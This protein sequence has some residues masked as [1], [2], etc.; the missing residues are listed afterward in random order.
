MQ[1]NVAGQ[2]IG[3]QLISSSDGSN[4]T[5]TVTVYVTGDAGTQ[6]IGSVGSGVCTHEGNG[7]HTYAPSQAETNYDLCAFTFIGTGA[8]SQTLQI[9][10]QHDANLKSI[11]GTVL[12][13]TAGQIAAGFKKVFDVAAPVF[14]AASINQTGDSYAR[15][16]APAGASV[17]ADVA[18][19]KS[20]SATLLARIGSFTGTGV[21]TILGM[22]KALLNK[23]ASTPSDVGGTFDASTDSTEAI[24]DNMGTA[25]TGDSYARL[26]APAGA[27]I[28]AD[29]AAI[30]AAMG[31]LVVHAGITLI[32]SLRMIG[33]LVA[34]KTAG[35]GSG[36]VTFRNPI[37]TL[38]AVIVTMTGLNRTAVTKDLSA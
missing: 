32:Q 17:S 13:E 9:Y 29:I 14:T 38:D 4:F 7:Y 24:R 18:A 30:P 15:L 31:A 27:S 12:T 33:A 22:F 36:S 10:T 25:Q 6:A 2:K 20:D 28:A 34:G 19:V 1:K 21:N 37:D 3:A 8:V 23:A 11:L 16:G 26:G 5:G 35:A